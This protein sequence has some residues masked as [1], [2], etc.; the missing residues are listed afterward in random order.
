MSDEL[1][2]EITPTTSAAEIAQAS[3][4]TVEA[5][6]EP[7]T[8]EPEVADMLAGG[9]AASE[10]GTTATPEVEEAKPAVRT[11]RPRRVA[12]ASRGRRTR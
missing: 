3:S 11:P 5:P 1:P 10:N 12:S 6:P 2:G 4:G 8:E 9:E 7:A